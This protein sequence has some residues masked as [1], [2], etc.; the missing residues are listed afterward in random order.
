MIVGS[1][2]EE[3]VDGE[4]KVGG[5]EN[6]GGESKGGGEGTGREVGHICVTSLRPGMGKAAGS[7]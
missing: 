6:T 4:R 1:H 3:D 2:T 5:R 7:I